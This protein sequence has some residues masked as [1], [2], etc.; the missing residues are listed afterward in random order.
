LL[1][2]DRPYTTEKEFAMATR[3]SK[4]AGG[5]SKS[6][7]AIALL[8]ADHERVE[9]LFKQVEKAADDPE[10]CREIV[11]T[12]CNELKVHAQLEEE[13]FYPAVR[14]AL[15]EDDVELIDE[16]EVEH[17]TAKQLI[18]RLEGMDAED[19][20][21]AACFKV[22]SEYVRHHVKEEEGEIFPKAKKTGLDLDA[23]G[24]DMRS[25]KEALKQELGIEDR[26]PAT[27]D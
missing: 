24:E 12:A 5:K 20:Y 27:V 1:P 4:R 26:E 21:Y 16:A 13:L 18:A 23:L 6:G 14:E 9:E 15:D 3:K 19:A 10:A 11:T 17:D 7:D 22:L 25:R 2:L 8:K